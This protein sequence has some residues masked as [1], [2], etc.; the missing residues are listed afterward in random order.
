MLKIVLGE[1]YVMKNDVVGFGFIDE[2]AAMS[3]IGKFLIRLF[4]VSVYLLNVTIIKVLGCPNNA[5]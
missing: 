1:K 5:E 3:L 4:Y 2:G